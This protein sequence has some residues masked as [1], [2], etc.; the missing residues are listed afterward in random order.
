VDKREH[1]VLRPF[2][3]HIAARL[4]QSWQHEMRRAFFRR[5]IRLGRF[6][7]DEKEFPLLDRL[8][9]PGDW[10]LDIGANVGHYTRRM[11]ELVG[12]D[13]R[14]I[15][16]EPIPATFAL[17]AAN[18][19]FFPHDNV[20]LLN[21]AASDSTMS[22][23]MH[24]PD[25][26]QGL[27]NYYQAHV[28]ADAAGLQVLTVNID[29]LGIPRRIKLVKMD[30]EGHELRVLRGM[31]ATIERH[32]PAMIVETASREVTALIE[33]MGYEIERLPNSSNIVC[34]PANANVVSE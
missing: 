18:A 32:R 1:G 3:K 6:V 10:V 4:P 28:S 9:E 24:I 19:R 22:V 33:S 31:R 34:R 2:L 30:V 14:V 12:P 5:E 27:H 17:L 29:A 7:T 15:A 26:Y 21:V 20:S 8:V 11:S 25:F 13:G 16:L 23:G